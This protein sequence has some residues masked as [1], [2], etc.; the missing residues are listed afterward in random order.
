MRVSAVAALLGDDSTPME[1][2]RFQVLAAITRLRQLA[3]HPRLVDPQG[4]PGSA[5]LARLVEL[6]NELRAEGRRPLVFSQFTEHLA[7]ARA[8]LAAEGLRL[9]YLDGSTPAAARSAEVDAFQAGE[10][11][12]FLLSLKAGGLGINL[13]SASEVVLLDPWWNPAVEDQA[14]DRA[15]RIGQTQ[16]VTVYRLVARGT[17][18]E[19]IL[20]MHTRKR[21]LVAGVLAGTAEAG[22][23]SVDELMGLLRGDERVEEGVDEPVAP[24]LK[25]APPASPRGSRAAPVP[26]PLLAAAPAVSGRHAGDASP[27]DPLEQA[28]EAY[29]AWVKGERTAGRISQSA[30]SNAVNPL[31]RLAS[32]GRARGVVEPSPLVELVDAYREAVDAGRWEAPP[33]DTDTVRGAVRKFWQWRAEGVQAK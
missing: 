2:R 29:G 21:D 1:R 31:R 17:V 27:S 14:A 5:K 30:A 32:F 19:E 16:R 28:L 18:E 9:R 25:V 6:V 13:T 8:A 11:D 7:L 12:A 15:H 20:A 3:C 10:G 26:H 24:P 23:L 22:A 33:S 4:P